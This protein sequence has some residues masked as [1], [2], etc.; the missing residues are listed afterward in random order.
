MTA[1]LTVGRF[2]GADSEG[3]AGHVVC[4]DKDLSWFTECVLAALLLPLLW[5]N[6]DVLLLDTTEIL[7]GTLIHKG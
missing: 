6:E 5:R 3:L 2:L 7:A 4:H 1:G